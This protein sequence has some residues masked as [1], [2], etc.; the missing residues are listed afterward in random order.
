MCGPPLF[1]IY[2]LVAEKKRSC[3]FLF[4]ARVG[5]CCGFCDFAV[6]FLVPL[7]MM[8]DPYMKEGKCS[9]CFATFGSARA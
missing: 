7:D 4:V 5:L 6:L 1:Q 3:N 2:M 9:G 8:R